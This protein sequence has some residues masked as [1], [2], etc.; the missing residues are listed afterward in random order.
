MSLGSFSWDSG[1]GRSPPRVERFVSEDSE[2]GAGG[3]VALDI[4]SVVDG[5]VSGGEALGRS[6]RFGALHLA[7]APSYG[8]MRILRT[9]AL[10]QPPH[11]MGC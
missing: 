4:E 8:L 6:W 3:E 2:R 9:I 10:A 11:M 5:G 7:L 1:C